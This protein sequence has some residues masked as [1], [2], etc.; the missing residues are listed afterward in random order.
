VRAWLTPDSTGGDDVA[1]CLLVP[2]DLLP[3]VT[4]ALGELLFPHNWELFGSVSVDDTI[5]ALETVIENYLTSECGIDQIFPE[6]AT[7]FWSSATL[8]TGTALLPVVDST[9]MFCHEIQHTTPANG[10]KVQFT[11]L[12]RAGTYSLTLLGRRST[13][14]GIL[15]CKVDG[16]TQSGTY[17]F[18]GSGAVNYNV[19]GTITV[20]GD[21]LHVIDFTVSQG[22]SAGDYLCKVTL[23]QLFRTGA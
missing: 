11:V 18:D 9:Q 17:T 14:G 7:V 23:M 13:N 1:R 4:G 19:S 5:E 22:S 10:D 6:G 20:I 12:L 2:A 8:V 3:Y 15:T 16:V 21:G